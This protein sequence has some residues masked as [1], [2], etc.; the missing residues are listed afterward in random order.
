MYIEYTPQRTPAAPLA[1][2]IPIRAPTLNLIL[3][4]NPN[5]NPKLAVG[6]ASYLCPQQI[7]SR[8]CHVNIQTFNQSE[9][10][11]HV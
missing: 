8:V 4:L 10:K 2:L 3:T 1:T 11:E 9:A 6:A 5:H 7:H